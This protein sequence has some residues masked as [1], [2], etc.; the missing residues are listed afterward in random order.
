M[1][2]PTPYPEKGVNGL[3]ANGNKIS[4]ATIQARYVQ[5][6]Y[7]TTGRTVRIVNGVIEEYAQ[8]STAQPMPNE[9]EQEYF[10][11]TGMTMQQGYAL[12][13]GSP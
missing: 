2:E 3:Y 13:M 10:N 5:W 9:T 11:R 4:T 6:L 7:K 12:W 8:L 1:A